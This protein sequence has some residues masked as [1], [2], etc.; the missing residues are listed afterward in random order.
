MDPVNPA[1]AGNP[2]LTTHLLVSHKKNKNFHPSK[3]SLK[4]V[5]VITKQMSLPK[6]PSPSE[7]FLNPH[8]QAK[9][10]R[11]RNR[12]V[13]S[14]FLLKNVKRE[15][16]YA[17]STQERPWIVML[18]LQH[19]G[20]GQSQLHDETDSVLVFKNLV[21]K[22][23]I[24]NWDGQEFLSLT[25]KDVSIDRLNQKFRYQISQFNRGELKSVR[26]F[27]SKTSWA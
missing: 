12:I 26:S 22:L 25:E 16:T 20:I 6:G 3:V 21:F 27:E 15:A 9:M 5:K 1:P 10:A 2:Q 11:R 23:R 24:L 17:G 18:K 4:R 13:F 8:V 7:N 14:Q 19:E